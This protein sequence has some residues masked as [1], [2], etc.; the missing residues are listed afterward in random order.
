[1]V[2]IKQFKNDQE[3]YSSHCC[4]WCKSPRA[5]RPDATGQ[6]CDKPE[7]RILIDEAYRKL[8]NMLTD[9]RAAYLL[10][11]T[12]SYKGN[13]DFSRPKLSNTVDSLKLH[14]EWLKKNPPLEK[15]PCVR[16]KICR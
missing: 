15:S 13:F 2:G 11:C 4:T 7:E 5:P 14:T 3:A 16:F 8:F 10:H 12:D 6:S 1:M 9:K